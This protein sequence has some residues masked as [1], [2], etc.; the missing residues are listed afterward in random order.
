MSVMPATQ[1]V[2]QEDLKF[3]ASLVQVSETLSQK[4]NENERARDLAQAVKHLPSKHE[5]LNFPPSIEG[6]K[7][8]RENYYL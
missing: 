8:V 3:E 7:K 6:K 4:Q 2:E 5:A 1:E